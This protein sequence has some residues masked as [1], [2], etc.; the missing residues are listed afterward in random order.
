M[1]MLGD[2]VKHTITGFKGIIVCTSQW[3]TGCDRVGVQSRRL[4]K[5]GAPTEPEW[6][7]ITQVTVTKSATKKKV[8]TDKG[9]PGPIPQKY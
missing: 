1:I 8:K 6:F 9:G 7:D 5:E 2:E 4:S 3:L